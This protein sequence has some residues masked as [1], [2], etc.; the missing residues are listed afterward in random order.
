MEGYNILRIRYLYVYICASAQH[1][2]LLIGFGIWH[3]ILLRL[4]CLQFYSS[5]YRRCLLFHVF[6]LLMNSLLVFTSTL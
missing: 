4:F 6:M 3:I 5:D 1:I 2:V